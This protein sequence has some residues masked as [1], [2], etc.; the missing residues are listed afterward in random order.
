MRAKFIKIA[1]AISFLAILTFCDIGPGTSAR[2][3]CKN[4][5]EN[6]IDGPSEGSRADKAK[7]INILPELMKNRQVDNDSDITDLYFIICVS[8]LI[9]LKKCDNESPLPYF[10]PIKY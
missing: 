1:I 3:S 5:K 10:I 8:N 2:D 9:E 7:C 6:K 4:S